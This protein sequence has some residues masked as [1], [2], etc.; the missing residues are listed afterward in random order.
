MV[1][2]AGAVDLTVEEGYDV[3]VC[4]GFCAGIPVNL[5]IVLT[6][7]PIA[8]WDVL[9]LASP[10]LAYFGLLAVFALWLIGKSESSKRVRVT[11]FDDNEVITL[12]IGVV[13]AGPPLI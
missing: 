7:D 6:H 5:Y 13:A 9:L 2:I 12:Q 10:L 1:S 4:H 11:G 3:P 8:L